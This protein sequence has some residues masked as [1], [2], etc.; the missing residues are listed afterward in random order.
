MYI[1]LQYFI[2]ANKLDVMHNK[3]KDIFFKPNLNTYIIHKHIVKKN[4]IWRIRHTSSTFFMLTLNLF[5]SSN[6][7]LK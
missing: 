7:Y 2:L 3:S 1:I 4:H 5:H 6:N